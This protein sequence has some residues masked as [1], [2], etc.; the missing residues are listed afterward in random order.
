M[1]LQACVLIHDFA[2]KKVLSPSTLDNMKYRYLLKYDVFYISDS[3]EMSLL[4]FFFTRK[5]AILIMQ[6]RL[7]HVRT[8][9]EAKEECIVEIKFL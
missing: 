2:L 3:I 9:V 6:R 5:E 7:P 8:K 1:Y 4:I